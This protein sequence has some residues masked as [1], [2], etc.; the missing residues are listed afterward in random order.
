[1]V[2]YGLVYRGG[3]AVTDN[4]QFVKWLLE[5]NSDVEICNQN[6]LWEAY[7]WC[8]TEYSRRFLERSL[9][10]QHKLPT[11]EEVLERPYFEPNFV[12]SIPQNRFFAAIKTAYFSIFDNIDNVIEFTT[13][14]PLPFKIKETESEEHALAYLNRELLMYVMP[15]SA[16]IRGDIQY[17][18][19]IGLNRVASLQ[20]FAIW[21]QQNCQLPQP[22]GYS[23]TYY[24]NNYLPFA[25]PALEAP[26]IPS[27]NPMGLIP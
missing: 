3:F 27:F 11:F 2:T 7:T 23:A 15:R 25:Y 22:W 20:A 9:N 18:R 19:Q 14:F 21:F 13:E 6:S 12:D 24:Q 17:I 5:T 16:Y 8:C 10:M 26:T 4:P 1:M